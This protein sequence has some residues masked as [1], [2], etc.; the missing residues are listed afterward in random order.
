SSPYFVK[1]FKSGLPTQ[2]HLSA[3]PQRVPSARL[4]Q[5]NPDSI[6]LQAPPRQCSGVKS[7]GQS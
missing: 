4:Q 2:G 1:L 5:D 7:L 3:R 6:G